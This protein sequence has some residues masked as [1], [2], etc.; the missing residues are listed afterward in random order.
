MGVL[1]NDNG[2]LREIGDKPS[3]GAIYNTR[4]VLTESGTYTA[5]VTGWHKVTCIGGGGGGAGAVGNSGTIAGGGGGGSGAIE[6]QYFYLQKNQSVVFTIGAG[7]QKG[8]FNNFKASD[9]GNTTFLSITAQGGG[10]GGSPYGQSGSYAGWGGKGGVS[11]NGFSGFSGQSVPM[12]TT[13]RHG[14]TGGGFGG[15]RT[16]NS[17]DAG[18]IAEKNA[19]GFGAGGAGGGTSPDSSGYNRDGGNGYQG[20]V[21]LE[22]Y[23]PDKQAA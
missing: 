16:V 11:V 8:L 10:G 5:K 23:D 21:I 13:G 12:G 9:G 7:G 18:Q 19:F 2:E 4:E 22:Y 17:T 15:A 20:A 3:G 1:Y 14:G 6:M